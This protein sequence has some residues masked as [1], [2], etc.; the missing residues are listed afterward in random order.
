MSFDLDEL[1]HRYVTRSELDGLRQDVRADFNRLND[2]IA[3]LVDQ[4][5]HT[6]VIQEKMVITLEAANNRFGSTQEQL[7]LLS[8]TVR[9]LE[10]ERLE[11]KARWKLF[12]GFKSV[13]GGAFKLIL[14]IIGFSLVS[15]GTTD[16][17]HWT[18]LSI[19]QAIGL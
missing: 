19:K 8:H 17:F 7:T 4:I 5:A 14:M 15:E 1:M 13:Y 3:K 16:F 11:Y 6:T 18:K 10:I 2:S 12:F 9:E